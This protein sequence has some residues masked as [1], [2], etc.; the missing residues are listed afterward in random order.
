[1][2][3]DIINLLSGRGTELKDFTYKDFRILQEK[4]LMIDPEI[5]KGKKKKK[6]GHH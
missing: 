1:M 3:V 4:R 5:M 2:R 6:L